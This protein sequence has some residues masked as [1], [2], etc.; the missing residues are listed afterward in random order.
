MAKPGGTKLR[1]NRRVCDSP[2][3]LTG[4]P[5]SDPLPFSTPADALSFQGCTRRLSAMNLAA[6]TTLFKASH[7]VAAGPKVVRDTPVASPGSDHDRSDAPALYLSALSSQLTSTP[8][9]ARRRELVKPMKY[10]GSGVT[11]ISTENLESR[12]NHGSTTATP[13]MSIR[14]EQAS[15][16]LVEVEQEA[17]TA[18]GSERLGLQFT[19]PIPIFISSNSLVCRSMAFSSGPMIPAEIRGL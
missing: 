9:Q 8:E 2:H 3:A 6:F 17:G 15:K 12:S 7:S 4:R 14:C 1:G 19:K 10:V 18:N 13:Q 5:C 16:R 11:C